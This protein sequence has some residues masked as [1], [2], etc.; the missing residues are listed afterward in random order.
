[1]S[2]NVLRLV[3]GIL[4]SGA[5]CASV[6]LVMCMLP[7]ACAC[8]RLAGGWPSTTSSGDVSGRGAH[9]DFARFYLACSTRAVHGRV[10]WGQ[11]RTGWRPRTR[12]TRSSSDHCPGSV[13]TSS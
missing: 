10:W 9:I 12:Q 11:T 1:M 8:L 4:I 3:L 7:N 13:R 5:C 6:D 2:L